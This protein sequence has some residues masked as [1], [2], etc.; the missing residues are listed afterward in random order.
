MIWH[1]CNSKHSISKFWYVEMI[2]RIL[3]LS[4]TIPWP[5][6]AT[7]VTY[8]TTTQPFT[9]SPLC[10]HRHDIVNPSSLSAWR[11]L[12][13]T[14]KG[15]SYLGPRDVW[16]TCHRSEIWRTP[17]CAILKRKK[18]LKNYSQ[19]GPARMFSRASLWLSTSLGGFALPQTISSY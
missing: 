18:N 11:H 13:T 5:G 3:A 12:R 15:V 19:R 9:L 2:S 6:L 10:Q 8:V 14:P 17:E 7:D 4:S 16:R 1:I